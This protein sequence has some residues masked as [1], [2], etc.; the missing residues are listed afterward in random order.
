[1]Q[2]SSIF[3]ACYIISYV[4]ASFVLRDSWSSTFNQQVVSLSSANTNEASMKDVMTPLLN[5]I[6]THIITLPDYKTPFVVNCSVFFD[7]TIEKI[8][9][10]VDFDKAEKA[11]LVNTATCRQ[12]QQFPIE[13]TPTLHK[14]NILQT[15]IAV[16]FDPIR[17]PQA[18]Y[19]LYFKL[20]PTQT[21]S[22]TSTISLSHIDTNSD[23]ES[24]SKSAS[25][26]LSSTSSIT[27]NNTNTVSDVLSTSNSESISIMVTPEIRTKNSLYER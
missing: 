11:E 25:L 12:N 6:S 19:W 2:R 13:Y 9:C 21:K 18:T 17:H 14:Y 27:S 15:S 8:T 20:P 3:L 16:G 7:T 5:L 10:D 4:R 26:S 1:M 22:V 23:T 24:I